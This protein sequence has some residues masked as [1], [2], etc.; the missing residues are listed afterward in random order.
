MILKQFIKYWLPVIFWCFLIFLF[1]SIPVLP[2]AK[3]FLWDF[4]LKKTAH[5]LEYAVLFF[6]VYR[7]L[8]N[9]PNKK[10]SFNSLGQKNKTIARNSLFF[11]VFYAFTDEYHQSFVSGRHSRFYDIFFDLIGGL[12]ALWLIKKW[13]KLKVVQ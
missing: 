5:V 12:L 3:I 9:S 7:A 1:S 4:I 6:L 13:K 11:V 8:I 2:N 10:I